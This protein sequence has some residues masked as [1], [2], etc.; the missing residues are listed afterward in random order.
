MKLIAGGCSLIQGAELQNTDN[1]W[2]GNI[3]ERRG[4]EYINEGYPGA[5][6]RY[7]AKR[8]IDRVSTIDDNVA[9]IVQW[10]YLSRYDYIC[11]F[12]T[13]E[14]NSPWYTLTPAHLNLSDKTVASCFGDEYVQRIKNFGTD[15]WA[16]VEYRMLDS[17]NELDNTLTQIL[18]LQE[19]LNNRN[20]PYMFSCAERWNDFKHW[21]TLKNNGPSICRSLYD[22]I[23][24]N[25]FKWFPHDYGDT[26]FVYW[27]NAHNFEKGQY[28][29]PLEEAHVAAADIMEPHFMEILNE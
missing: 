13:K 17:M 29:H 27:A 3:A 16:E 15:K 28:G 6:N 2:T 7:I 5:G 20:I 8:I 24:W 23:D 10:S 22:S 25:K 19:Y 26:G 12:D 1:T 21:N 9:V 14:Q 4:F 11:S 18:L